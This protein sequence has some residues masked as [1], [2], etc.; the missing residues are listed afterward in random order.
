MSTDY[1]YSFDSSEASSY[2]SDYVTKNPTKS[3]WKR[4]WQC[5]CRFRWLLVGLS[6]FALYAHWTGRMQ[7]AQRSGQRLEPF[8]VCIGCVSFSGQS[9]A[10][11]SWS[12]S[13]KQ[14]W[15]G[16]AATQLVLWT[17]P[18]VCSCPWFCNFCSVYLDVDRTRKRQQTICGHTVCVCVG[19]GL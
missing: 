6:L 2:V 4:A 8:V 7:Q 17:A 19:F 15:N 10:R 13:A 16:Y 18:F 9:C 14:A 11:V 1:S 5:L 12:A 3:Q